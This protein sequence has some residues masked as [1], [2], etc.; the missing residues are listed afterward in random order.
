MSNILNFLEEQPFAAISGVA[1]TGKTLIAVEK[2]RRHAVNGD[3][4][5]FLC[6]NKYLCN[7]LRRNYHYEN[8]HY[9]TIDGFACS[10]CHSK[11]A[12]IDEL[13]TRLIEMSYSDSFPYKHIIVDE[14]QDFGQKRVL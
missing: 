6:F 5:L 3:N 14:G 11:Y 13:E 10:I 9:Y 12:D 7:H 4:V 2:A 1:G 8:V